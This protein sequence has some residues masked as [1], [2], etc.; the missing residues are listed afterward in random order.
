MTKILRW[1]ESL[2]ARANQSIRT[3]KSEAQIREVQ[4]LPVL[5]L[6]DLPPD[7]SQAKLRSAQGPGRLGSAQ[8]GAGGLFG[9]NL[10]VG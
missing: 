5:G 3:P 10:G 2:L 9:S 1:F 7:L 8:A 6:G 4:S